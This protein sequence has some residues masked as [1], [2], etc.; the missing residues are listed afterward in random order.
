MPLHGEA[1]MSIQRGQILGV[2][3]RKVQG[4]LR[5]GSEL[6]NVNYH[7]GQERT[8]VVTSRTAPIIVRLVIANA[9]ISIMPI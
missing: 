7:S 6:I 2:S 8:V 9:I 4:N 1:S 5:A 3:H